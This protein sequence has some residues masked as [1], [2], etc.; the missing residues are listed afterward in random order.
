MADVTTHLFGVGDSGLGVLKTGQTTSYETGDDGDLEEGIAKDY[1]ELTTGDYSG[2]TNITINGKT[3]ALSNECVQ[4]N[5]TGLMW[6]RYVPLNDIGPDNNG[7]LLWKDAANAED[8]WSFVAQANANSLGGHDD[9]R[10]PNHFEMITLLDL[11][12]PG[13]P[14]IDTDVFPLTP[15]LYQWTSTSRPGATTNA[16][17]VR[18]TDGTVYGYAKTTIKYPV[19]LVRG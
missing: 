19:R 10:I 18:F 16:F 15:A 3:H 2:T 6:A 12:K 9:W 14:S 1:T 17:A 7:K 8:I 13:P 11:G 4:D 5:A